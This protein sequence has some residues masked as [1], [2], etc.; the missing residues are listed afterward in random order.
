[1]LFRSPLHSA[2]RIVVIGSDRMMAAVKAARHAVLKPYLRPDHQAIGSI[3]SPMQCMMKEICAQCLQPHRDPD[4]GKVSYVFSCFNQDQPL[5]R[6]DW[7]GL[8]QRLRQNGVQE[9]LTAQWISHCTKA[10][11]A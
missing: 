5:D 2:T 8:D 7:P 6:V 3:N 11:T 10:L 1:M 4:T 9:K